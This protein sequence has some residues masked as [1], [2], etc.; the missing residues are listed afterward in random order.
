MALDNELVNA[1]HEVCKELGQPESVAK[2]LLAWMKECSEKQLTAA[3]DNQ[4]LELLRQAIAIGSEAD[5]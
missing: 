1:V 3:E 2:R 4:H 5:L